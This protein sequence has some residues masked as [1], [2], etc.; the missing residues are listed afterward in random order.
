MIFVFDKL[1]LFQN[2]EP[3]TVCFNPEN[4]INCS[5][6]LIFVNFKTNKQ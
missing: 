3:F 2:W 5:K 6:L 4:L 1:L